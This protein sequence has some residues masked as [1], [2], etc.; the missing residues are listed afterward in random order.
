MKR[1]FDFKLL[2]LLLLTCCVLLL[3]ACGAE[4]GDSV[5]TDTPNEN[6]GD[7]IDTEPE[8]VDEVEYTTVNTNSK[9]LRTVKIYGETKNFTNATEAVKSQLK[10]AGGYVETSEITGGES[11]YNGSKTPKKAIYVLRIP[12][13]KLDSYV[14]S[15]KSM[16]NVTSYSETTK[17]VTLNYYDL[18]SRIKT[19]EMKKSSLEALLE[20]AKSVNEIKTYQD[21]LFSVITEIESLKSKL[22]VY[23]NKVNYSTVGLQ[24]TEVLEYTETTPEGKSFGDKLSDTFVA[25]WEGMGTFFEYFA[26]FIVAVFP[27]LLLLGVVAAIVIIIVK[28]VKRKKRNKYNNNNQFK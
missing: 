15:L 27:A 20:N 17:D 4:S 28:L 13:D 22:N 6:V 1:P 7:N 5:G 16:L 2:L 3:S 26:I 25:S 23:D 18:Q 11:L 12:A 19:L 24:I 9:I 8:K 10:A 21:E 14:E